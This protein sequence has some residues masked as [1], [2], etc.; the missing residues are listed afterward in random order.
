MKCSDTKPLEPG[1]PVTVNLA[2]GH[3]M[4]EGEIAESYWDDGW[5]YRIHVTGGDDCTAYREKDG[6]LWVC[7]FEVSVRKA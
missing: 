6:Q 4:A 3:A 5:M 2:Q 7:D 1:T